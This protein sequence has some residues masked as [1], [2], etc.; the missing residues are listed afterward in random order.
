[1]KTNNNLFHLTT[2]PNQS[3]FP[4]YNLPKIQF[5]ALNM[6]YHFE[7]VTKHRKAPTQST[8]DFYHYTHA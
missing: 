8:Y 1:M 5:C 2:P 3:T 7:R 4:L 6:F